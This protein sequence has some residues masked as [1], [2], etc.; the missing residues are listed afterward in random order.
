MMTRVAR[1]FL[2]LFGF[3][4]LVPDRLNAQGITATIT[5]V[6]SDSTGG[7]L[8]GA[9]VTARR[10][11][12][13]EDRVATTTA[14]GEF[15]IPLLQPGRYRV[16]VELA[17]FKTYQQEFTLAINQKAEINAV[18]EV[19]SQTDKVT[20]T[21]EAPPIQTEDSSVGLV[22]DSATITNTPLNGRLNITG[23]MALAP[24]IQNAGSQDSI[25]V[26]GITPS[27][28]GASA[29]GSAGFSID[30][31]TNTSAFLQ[32]GY[33]EYPPLD[34][35]REFKTMT[36]GSPAEFAQPT[37]VIVV[38]RGG[39]N[40][41]H[42]MLL[43]FNRNRVTAA[44][45]YFAGS[46]PLPKY[47]RNEFGGNFS[48]PI[49]IPHLY[50]GRDRSFFF[51]N[52]E[53]FRR[54][55]AS[56]LSSQM[57]TARERN[58]D[59]S[60]FS[61]A[62]IDPLTQTPFPGNQIPA[63]RLNSVSLALQNALF[64]L[65][66]KA[67]TSTNLV[68]NVPLAEDVDRFSFRLDHRISSKDSVFA[69]YIAGLFG[70]NP[71]LGAT[72]KFG[73]MAGIGERNMNTIVG[74]THIFSPTLLTQF[75]GSYN[76]VPI[77][78]TPQNVKTD[79][80]SII[81]GLGPQPL[82]GAPQLTISNITSVAE[83]GS[84]DL[85][86]TFQLTFIVTKV[87][88]NHSVK[89]G[90]SFLRSN[91]WNQAVLSPQRGAF[92]FNGQYTRS[93]V[94]GAQNLGAAYADFILG[95]P[96]QTQKANPPASTIRF[97][98]PQYAAFIQD[99]W[100]VTPR[101][102]LNMGIRYDL[103]WQESNPYGL[104]SMFVPSLKQIVVFA[105]Q[106]P[107][108]ALPSVI[109]SVPVVLAPNVGLPSDIWSYLGQ[110]TN[111]VAP[112]FGFAYSVT[113][114]T[115][116][117]GAFGIYYNLF[118]TLDSGNPVFTGLPFYSVQT[119]SQT[120]STVPAITMSNPFP[121]SGTVAT[122]PVAATEKSPVTP[123]QEQWNL[124]VER[125]LPWNFGLRVGYVGSRSL[126]QNNYH[127][128][129]NVNPDLNAF[130]P[131]AGAVQPN[132]PIQPFSNIYWY[133]APIFSM[134]SNAAQV[135][136]HKQY[137]NG[138]TLNAEYQ[139]IR[140]LGTEN[141]QNSLHTNDSYGNIGTIRPHQL[142][143]SY[144]YELPFG[145]NKLFFGSTSGFANT[146]ISGWSISGITT[147]QSGS[148]FSVTKASSQLGGISSRAFRNNGVPLYPGSKTLGAWFNT[149]AFVNPATNPSQ[150]FLYGNSAYNMLWGPRYQ[151]WDTAVSKTTRLHEN[152]NLQIRVDAFNVFNHPTFNNPAANVS[153]A[154]TVGTITATNGASRTLQLGGK[155]TF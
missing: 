87:L 17:S 18:L 93:K 16:T 66:N 56:T 6:I 71:S 36:T 134:N 150:D 83:Q 38:T 48:G 126:K 28:G 117:R 120:S 51:F 115:V 25:P 74:W 125:Q 107:A 85:D 106:M 137:S 63:S 116:V 140:V 130:V 79:F 42:G 89:T 22:I 29:F 26:Y 141:F 103:Q 124:A 30:G 133:D 9:R 14:N 81:P 67:G 97:L 5:G 58:G 128:G 135:G 132:R 39:G 44:K 154:K 102:T 138:F 82:E 11:E 96:T 95:Y 78:R 49:S 110:D 108:A 104:N 55:Q 21:A 70:P 60:E 52:Y 61:D 80:A 32:R 111:N 47:N 20:V 45:N 33:G 98:Q 12:T 37:Q 59:F 147:F 91:H 50:D 10:L 46:S 27:V 4:L 3:M 88:H 123:Y 53:G 57:P 86:Q 112:R 65:P 139:Y 73:G 8:S 101:L 90:F 144:A 94:S 153:N 54:R 152:I 35:I 143:L 148:P 119:Y 142:Q 151:N 68:E 41:Y 24:G 15:N 136:L 72:S 2:I 43:A 40:Q 77:Y 109:A 69:S 146:F 118:P 145:K 121:G 122:N 1:L 13:N 155:L 100:R 127:G 129:G 7:V 62:I 149:A 114:K 99:D 113:P 34:G 23:L 76:H 131:V 64:P 31:A 75:I 19:G 84:K 92:N 105:K